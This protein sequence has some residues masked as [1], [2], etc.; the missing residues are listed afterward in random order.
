MLCGKRSQLKYLQ[1][2]VA[3]TIARRQGQNQT[4]EEKYVI[5]T[6]VDQHGGVVV[7]SGAQPVYQDLS[8]HHRGQNLRRGH[9]RQSFEVH[10]PD[11]GVMYRANYGFVPAG[12]G[13]PRHHHNFEQ[14]RFVLD[15]KWEY[16]RRQRFGAGWL[17][18]FGE[19]V[20]YG[21]QQCLEDSHQIVIQYPGPS[22]ARF[23]SQADER[24][25]Q[26]EMVEQGIRFEDGLC[27]WPDSKKQD[28]SEALW[29]Y[30]SGQKLTYPKPR[31]DEQIWL[32]TEL[33]P[34]QPSG[35]PGIAIKR[36]AYF[37][38][39][40][41]AVALIRMDP[42]SSTPAGRTSS[43][44]MRFVYEGDVEYAGQ[45][46]PQVSSLYYPPNVS[47]EPL[48]SAKGATMLSVELQMG[49]A[50]GLPLPYRV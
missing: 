32:N 22:G 12:P 19:G 47:Y 21:P 37:D 39:C 23:I 20:F 35:V 50:S 13:S 36:L 28:G 48:H 10:D 8:Q 6:Q 11:A 29:E 49:L 24:R 44:M 17:G 4:H 2:T 7:F 45:A 38:A 34:W 40:G 3:A 25:V 41:P 30:W 1:R 18:F 16:G 9:E 46:C 14:L 15:G 33:F 31:Y 43:V 26:R 27:L 5:D 42:G